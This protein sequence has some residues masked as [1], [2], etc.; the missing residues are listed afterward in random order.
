M[1]AR[2]PSTLVIDS[3]VDRVW[4]LRLGRGKVDVERRTTRTIITLA[5]IIAAVG[6]SMGSANGK[7]NANAKLL[8]GHIE[9]KT[10]A[11]KKAG[12]ARVIVEVYCEDGST[13]AKN[14][15]TDTYGEFI[16]FTSH[17]VNLTVDGSKTRADIRGGYHKISLDPIGP[18]PWKFSYVL[19]LNFDDGSH[20][21]YIRNNMKICEKKPAV[22]GAN[23]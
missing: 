23:L 17:T 6:F 1:H 16:D 14:S 3:P 19:T 13:A 21:K 18:T 9:F 8:N 15:P 10:G 20:L 22:R 4:Q 11:G 7:G 5:A 12:E 2:S